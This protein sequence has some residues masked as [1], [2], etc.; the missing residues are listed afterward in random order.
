MKVVDPVAVL[1]QFVLTHP[2]QRAAAAALGISQAYLSDLLNARRDLS[3][4]VLTKLNLKT[5]VVKN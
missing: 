1:K 2:N 4:T 5:I 3:D